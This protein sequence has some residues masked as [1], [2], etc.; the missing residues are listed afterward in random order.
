MEHEGLLDSP[1][2]LFKKTQFNRIAGKL[3][4]Q[5]GAVVIISAAFRPCKQYPAYK[6]AVL[7]L[8]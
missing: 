2:C 7:S 3:Y 5:T 1:K 8:T 6:E 4:V